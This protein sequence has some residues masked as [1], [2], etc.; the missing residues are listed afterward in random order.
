M[1]PQALIAGKPV[2]SYDI[3]GAREV[4]IPDETGVLVPPRDI[5]A[6]GAALRRLATDPTLRQ[7]F[8]QEGRRRL[9][10]LFRHERMTAQLRGLYEQVLSCRWPPR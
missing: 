2:V 6:L 9:T 8:G 1:L 7:R 10:D 5:G 3:D 4:V